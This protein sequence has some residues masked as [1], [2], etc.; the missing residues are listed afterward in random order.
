MIPMQDLH[1]T[2]ELV[3][4]SFTPTLGPYNPKHLGLQAHKSYLPFFGCNVY[5]SDLLRNIW[6]LEQV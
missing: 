3:L 5:E 2:V 6:S 4:V 1:K